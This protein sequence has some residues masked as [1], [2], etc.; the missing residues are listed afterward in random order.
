MPTSR[1]T[2]STRFR[3]LVS[4]MPVDD[5]AALLVLLEPVDAADHGRLA[6]ARRAAD[7]DTLAAQDLQV[8]VAEDM[9][10]AV[11]LVDLDHLHGDIGR[12]RLLADF[13]KIARGDDVFAHLMRPSAY[14]RCSAGAP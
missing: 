1:R 6:G 12:I 8:D 5:D 2:S 7:H 10:V 9:K 13:G 4:S 11:P 3:S 14:A